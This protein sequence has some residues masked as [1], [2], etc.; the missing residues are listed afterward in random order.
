MKKVV[1]LRTFKG[2][3]VL[4]RE[5]GSFKNENQIVKL[6]HDTLDWANFMKHLP[7]NPFCRVDVEKVLDFINGKWEEIEIPKEIIN[8]VKKA[9][10]GSKEVKLTPQEQKI[11]DLEAKLEKLLSKEEEPM[12]ENVD[13]LADLQAQYEAKFNKKPHHKMGIKKLKEELT[14]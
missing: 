7:A 9:H 13:E 5:D 8:E 3:E 10:V 2:M 11:A 6:T 14:K 12:N 1:W 4:K